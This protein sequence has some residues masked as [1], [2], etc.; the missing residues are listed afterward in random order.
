[1]SMAR[2]ESQIISKELEEIH[3]LKEWARSK[4]KGTLS[5]SR[6]LRSVEMGGHVELR[7]RSV[8]SICPSEEFV[9]DLLKRCGKRMGIDYVGR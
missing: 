6:I 9:D 3:E 1:M 7:S 4:C 5:E 2:E 8:K